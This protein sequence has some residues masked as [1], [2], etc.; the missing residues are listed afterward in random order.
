MEIL[1][2]QNRA[3]RESIGF[4]LVELLVVIG[5]IALLVAILLP[6]LSKS[7]EMAR[8]AA[9][10]SNLR[11]VHMAFVLYA[12]D[13][14]DQVPLVNRTPSRQY[15]SMM[16]STTAGNRWVLFGLLYSARY[17]ENPRI[18]F[19]PSENNSKFDFDTSENPVPPPDAMPTANMQS[20]Y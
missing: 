19:C 17:A 14:H 13:N 6:A 15:T 9:C 7:R 10:L 16:S 4:T 2:T 18:F 3:P 12:A 11:Q 8:R 1:Q 5:I 20:G